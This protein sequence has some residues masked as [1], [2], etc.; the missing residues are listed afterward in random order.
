MG[1]SFLSHFLDL[2]RIDEVR[3]QIPIL[4]QKRIDIY[5]TADKI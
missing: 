4:K 2:N 5:T 3:Q 1:Y